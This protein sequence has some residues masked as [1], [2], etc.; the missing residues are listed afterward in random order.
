M[1]YMPPPSRDGLDV[2]RGTVTV[3]VRRKNDGDRL[4]LGSTYELP[5]F[6]HVIHLLAFGCEFAVGRQRV[7]PLGINNRCAFC[8]PEEPVP[9]AWVNPRPFYFRRCVSLGPLDR[10]RQ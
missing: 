6:D 5:P 1:R 3:H 8:G 7:L 2:A 10:Q 9:N 4:P